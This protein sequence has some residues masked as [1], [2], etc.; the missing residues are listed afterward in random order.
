MTWL[1]TL[2]ASWAKNKAIAWAKEKAWPWIK[3]NWKGL[4]FAGLFLFVLWQGRKIDDL[5]KDYADQGAVLTATQDALTKET[6]NKKSQV[7]ALEADIAAQK[8]R[9]A[10]LIDNISAIEGN[11]DKDADDPVPGIIGA[12]I[13]RLYLRP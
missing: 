12:G 8:E 5:E 4:V 2:L 11:H 1:A 7:A 3:D 10:E 13:D 6:A 9:E